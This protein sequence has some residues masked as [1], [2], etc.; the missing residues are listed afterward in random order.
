MDNTIKLNPIGN[1]DTQIPGISFGKMTEQQPTVTTPQSSTVNIPTKISSDTLSSQT[2]QGSA[3]ETPIN[4]SNLSLDAQSGAI[5]TT[6]TAPVTPPTERE[7]ALKDRQSAIDLYTNPDT[8][9]SATSSKLQQESGL[10]DKQKELDAL[11][12]KDIALQ[13]QQK[14]FEQNMLNKNQQGLFGGA[15]QQAITQYQRDISSQRADLAIQKLALQGDIKGATDLITLKLNAQFEPVKQ[16]IDYLDKTLTIYGNDLSDSQKAKLELEKTNLQQ[17]IKS[18]EDF[19][20]LL[21]DAQIG[22]ATVDEIKQASDRF[23]Q[24][25]RTGA[26]SIIGRYSKSSNLTPYQQFQATESISKDTETRTAKAQE[27]VR[28]SA[29]MNDALKNLKAGGNKSIATQAII[30]TFNKILDPTSTVREGEYDRTAQGQSLLQQIEGKVGNIVRGGGGVTDATLEDAVKLSN[31]YM[32]GAKSSIAQQNKRA[33]DFANQFGLNSNL[34]TSTKYEGQPITGNTI[35]VNG[36][37][38]PTDF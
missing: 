19:Q 16:R 31:E 6:P 30:A 1:G 9:Y 15:G 37:V 22:G 36:K 32:T 5:M 21:D 34:V 2:P 23:A 26:L 20:K 35:T 3:I 24:G 8:G 17:T 10:I 12:V 27:I 7:L 25:D 28:Q 29:I 18:K 11:G 13:K 38:L 14:D 33:I 4:G